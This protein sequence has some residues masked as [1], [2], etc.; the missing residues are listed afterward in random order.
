MTTGGQS[1]DR[2]SPIV[3]TNNQWGEEPPLSEVSL[4]PKEK[5]TFERKKYRETTISS[6][7]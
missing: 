6:F 3:S 5:A 7:I 1:T 2:K 4:Y